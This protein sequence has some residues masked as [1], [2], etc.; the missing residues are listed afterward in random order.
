[1]KTRLDAMNLG[2]GALQDLF[3]NS[4]KK[5]MANINDPSTKATAVRKVSL[6]ITITPD[7]SRSMAAIV[8]S[9]ST[10]LA[11]IKPVSTAALL[12]QQDGKLTAYI[13]Q[14]EEAETELPG[15][16]ISME[17]RA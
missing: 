15:N 13:H 6:E 12:E 16:I 5:V 9:A 4:M 3:E 14:S 10:T 1:M 7:E 8:V 17:K 11:H 2:D